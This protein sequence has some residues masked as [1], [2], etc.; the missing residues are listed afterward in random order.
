MAGCNAGEVS[1]P[2]GRRRIGW[3]GGSTECA[4]GCSAFHSWLT[5]GEPEQRSIPVFSMKG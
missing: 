4:S 1:K 5:V 3:C 2:I